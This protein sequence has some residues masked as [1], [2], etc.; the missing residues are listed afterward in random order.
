MASPRHL[1]MEESEFLSQM[2]R[3]L[4]ARINKLRQRPKTFIPLL[5]QKLNKYRDHVYL[6]MPD[7]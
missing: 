1:I 3:Q 6:M 5:S 4:L 2:T 7:G